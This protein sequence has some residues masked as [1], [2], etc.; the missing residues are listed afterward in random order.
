[1]KNFPNCLLTGQKSNILSLSGYLGVQENA[2]RDV[3]KDGFNYA[4]VSIAVVAPQSRGT[5]S[6]TSKDMKDPPLVNP[7]WLTDLA[8]REVL[9]AGIKRVR[10]L[11][12][13]SSMQPVLIGTEAFPGP[14]M[15][16]DEEILG[17]VRR[18]TSTVFHAAATCA[19][20]RTNDTLA[21]V[22]SKARVI[23]V[24]NLRVVDASSLPF[25]PPG[26]PIATVVSYEPYGQL[27]VERV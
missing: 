16:T 7:R 5:I 11:F 8:D 1:L 21:V 4:T 14:E 17:S 25:L 26:H 24:K 3:P 13:T 18:A 10:E 19:M 12:A 23:G 27:H 15:Q 6:I 20:G 2:D 9:L 22:D